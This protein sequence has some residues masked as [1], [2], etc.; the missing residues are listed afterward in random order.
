[1]HVNHFLVSIDLGH[2][3]ILISVHF[4]FL[5]SGAWVCLNNIST[6]QP[7]VLSVLTQ[8]LTVV[9]DGL[10]GNKN[11]IV[12]Q[13]DEIALSPHGACFGTLNYLSE[14]QNMGFDLSVGFFSSFKS[15]AS[16]LPVE[17][18]EMFRPVALVGPD[19][20]VILQVWLLGQGFTQVSSLASRIVTLKGF[21]QKFLPSSLKTVPE[22]LS[23]CL[24]K[25][26]G[27]GAHCLKRMIEDAGSHLCTSSD[28]S[29]N[30]A[31]IKG[32]SL[33]GERTESRTDFAAD[34]NAPVEALRDEGK[35]CFTN[36]VLMNKKKKLLRKPDS[37]F[38]GPFGK[39]L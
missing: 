4:I 18:L 12:F 13:D 19:L 11:S 29:D 8:L 17:L 38:K 35:E 27:W 30:A 7:A 10:R 1:M 15:S 5:L 26:T 37:S 25:C 6:I 34:E 20:Q 14:Q 22:G 16:F 33:D 9:L 36:F 21:C 32:P 24:H 3:N 31:S 28:V 2:F 23:S 39:T